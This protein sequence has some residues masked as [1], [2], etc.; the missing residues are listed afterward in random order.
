M[1]RLAVVSDRAVLVD[2]PSWFDLATVSGDDALADPMTAVARHAELHDLAA[3]LAGATPG[4]P[5]EGTTFGVCVPRPQKVVGIGLNYRSHASESN[6]Q[7]PPSPLAFTKF[8]SCLVGPTDDVVLSGASVDWEVEIVAVIGTG[9]RHIAAADAWSHVAGLTLG[10]DISDRV[11]QLV[12]SPPQFSLGKSFDTFG[13]IGPA[14]VSVDAFPDPDDIG[15]WCDVAGERMQDART[16]DLIFSIPE[17]V[18]YLSSIC[19]LVPGDLIFTGTPA[20]VGGPRGRFLADG[21][22]IDSGAEVIGSLRN[23]CVAAAS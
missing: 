8:P 18:A 2:G 7:L 19:T 11:V 12:G 10:Q 13:P 17:L 23:R 16:T 9:G 20:G 3:S 5:V 14:V 15:L 22:V 6:L 4:G 1:F 21:E